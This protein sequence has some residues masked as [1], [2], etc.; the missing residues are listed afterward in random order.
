MWEGLA[1]GR[2]RGYVC[3]C[4]ILIAAVVCVDKSP[5]TIMPVAAT[6]LL[7]LAEVVATSWSCSVELQPACADSWVISICTNNHI[8]MFIYTTY[9]R[10][11]CLSWFLLCSAKCTIWT[12]LQ[13]HLPSSQLHSRGFNDRC[14]LSAN[15]NR[16]YVVVAWQ[17]CC[18]W[19]CGYYYCWSAT[20]K[21]SWDNPFWRSVHL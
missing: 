16:F 9:H 6:V 13:Q 14:S 10:W 12:S 3:L 2:D 5:T 20:V 19:S 17:E 11:Y 8:F 7:L 15:S 18:Q 1:W 4:T 21:G